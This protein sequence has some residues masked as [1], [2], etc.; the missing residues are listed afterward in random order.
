MLPNRRQAAASLLAA[1]TAALPLSRA[2]AA[3]LAA[4]PAVG[5][6]PAPGDEIPTRIDTGHDNFEHMMGPVSINGQGP[7]QF[8][9]DTGANVSCVSRDLAQRLMLA[10]LP[11]A[12]VHTIVGVR[13]RPGV[14]IDH[15][16]VGERKRRSV[17]AAS[18]PLTDG[19][20]GVLGIDW[21]TGQRLELGFKA[22][23]LAI[24][25]SR[26]D[27]SREG[28]AVVPA[29][30][31]LGQL[32][33]VDA[34]VSG[35]RINAII[36][37]GSQMTICNTALRELVAASDRR[38]GRV[39]PYQRLKMETLI[40]EQFWGELLYVPFMRLGGLH[41]GNVPVVYS[42]M[43]VFDIWDLKNKPSVVLGMDL[44]TQFDSV[45]MD[46]GRSQVRFDVAEPALPPA[47]PFRS[48]AI[49]SPDA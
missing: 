37:S 27:I 10:E 16:Q 2:V 5:E 36:D 30:R 25:R 28:S 45:A 44:L 42:D 11:P 35:K 9:I 22:K 20:D 14:L 34:D 3:P 7:F 17:R 31:R 38:H 48:A 47:R 41:L 4:A 13:E 46:F 39:G 12:R 40:G 21:L 1:G 26:E 18:L 29:R 49:S 19:L 6:A 8:L 15:L 32:T 24:T 23:S 33:I 43:H